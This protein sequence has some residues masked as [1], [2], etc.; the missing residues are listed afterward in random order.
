MTRRVRDV[1][2]ALK[3]NLPGGMELVW[4]T[5]EGR[6]IEASVWS[7]WSNVGEGI[8]LTAAILF[9]FLYNLRTLLVICITMPLTI[10]IGLFFM[11]MADFTLNT[12]TL[13]AF[14]MSVGILVANSIVV[15]E[16][17][18]RRLDE[19]KPPKE[20]A[21]L[22]AKET[23]IAVLASA[24]TNT[25]VL[26]PLATMGGKVGMF[27]KPLALTMVIVTLVSLFISFTLT[28][29][30]C[31]ILLTPRDPNRRTLLTRLESLWNRRFAALV[32]KYRRLI[33][34][35][36][37]HRV[38]AV[39]VM[40][41]IAGMLVQ[42]MSLAPDIGF[43]LFQGIDRGEV[44]VKLEYPTRYSLDETWRRVRDVEARVTDLTGLRHRMVTVGKVEGML[45]QSSEGVY[46]AQLLLRFPE[47]DERAATVDQFIGEI[48]S[49]LQNY[50]EAV[51]SV[52][53][54]ATIG[55]GMQVPV[56][57]EIAGMSLAELDRLALKAQRLS[58]EIPG[59]RDI[60]STVRP[61]KPELLIRPNRPVLSDR[62]ISATVLG[63]ALRGNIEGLTAG[64][65]KENARNYD[66]VVRMEKQEGKRQVSSFQFPGEPG[67]AV[68]LETLSSMYE[69]RTP[70]QITR[71]DKYRISKLL[72][73][74]ESTLP[75]GTAV[76]RI[77]EAIREK[78][79][80]PPGYEYRF[81]GDYE[82]MADAQSLLGEAAIIAMVLVVLCLAAILESFKQPV[83]ILVTVPYRSSA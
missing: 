49:R 79:V 82:R 51:V 27:I 26:F 3:G 72:A 69:T 2:D 57:M 54:P 76:G 28:P 5:D 58:E 31:S 11:Q 19:G 33:D 81:T 41:L 39:L 4:V 80:F 17:I 30:L 25:V 42:S 1:V 78:G 66:I 44:I 14:G 18:V 56:E 52:G 73:N 46:L 29:M 61:G 16:G 13:I 9:V 38:A 65:F 8:V 55:G 64:T 45:G 43:D 77:T 63:M 40:L 60:D 36:G 20:A 6:F 22:G 71:K 23:F 68:P 34:A 48:R 53:K 10:V 35:T 37:R 15:L 12:A 50:P 24:A 7:A 32:E 67:K 59:L 62:G 74:L 70:I 21:A 83:L 47:R 75:L